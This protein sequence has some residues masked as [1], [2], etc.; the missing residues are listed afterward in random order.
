MTTNP[1]EGL[2][3]EETRAYFQ[4]AANVLDHLLDRLLDQGY[5]GGDLPVV[6]IRRQQVTALDALAKIRKGN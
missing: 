1:L 5:D 3:P 2:T 6:M 4:G